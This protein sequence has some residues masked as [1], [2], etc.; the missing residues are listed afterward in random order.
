MSEQFN[1]SLLVARLNTLLA[2]WGALILRKAKLYNPEIYPTLH[3]MPG[4]PE[5]VNQALAD[6]LTEI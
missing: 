2:E 4:S 6:A 5:A 3:N 1:L